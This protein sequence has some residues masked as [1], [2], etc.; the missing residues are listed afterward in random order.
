MDMIELRRDSL[1]EKYDKKDDGLDNC[2]VSE[3]DSEDT[4]NDAVNDNSEDSNDRDRIHQER[5]S[6][7]NN[8]QQILFCGKNKPNHEW[9]ADSTEESNKSVNKRDSGLQNQNGRV[10]KSRK[11]R[12]DNVQMSD[13]RKSR[14]DNVQ[15]SDEIKS[16]YDKVQ[17][18]DERKSRNDDTEPSED[19]GSSKTET[20]NLDWKSSDNK[21]EVDLEDKEEEDKVDVRGDAMC[22]DVTR[23][24]TEEGDGKFIMSA[25]CSRKST[26]SAAVQTD[27]SDDDLEKKSKKSASIDSPGEGNP[28]KKRTRKVKLNPRLCGEIFPKASRANG[29]THKRRPITAEFSVASLRTSDNSQSPVKLQL[30]LRTKSR[31]RRR[32]PK[33]LRHNVSLYQVQ[34]KRDRFITPRERIVTK[35][36]LTSSDSLTNA[37]KKKK[38]KKRDVYLRKFEKEWAE[39]LAFK[40]SARRNSS[41]YLGYP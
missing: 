33:L 3:S 8:D 17:V 13:E 20:N 6:K 16:R 10:V 15:V 12:Y 19:E 4:D 36:L 24:R 7:H 1:E 27:L 25:A 14:F 23:P 31:V 11:S 26:T 41:K 21:T 32:S 34:C 35:Y 18:S 40:K 37:R 22:G 28:K 29:K 2:T 39:V 30:K 9:A 38:A 5:P